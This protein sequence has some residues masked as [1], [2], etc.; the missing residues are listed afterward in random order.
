MFPFPLHGPTCDEFS[1]VKLLCPLM[2]SKSCKLQSKP[3]NSKISKIK[4]SSVPCLLQFEQPRKLIWDVFI[5]GLQEINVEIQIY[6]KS[7]NSA[8]LQGSSKLRR[9]H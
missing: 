1:Q 4:D 9:V 6:F 8:C 5:Q 3:L 7:H 2:L